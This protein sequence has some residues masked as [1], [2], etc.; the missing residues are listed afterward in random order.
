M[1]AVSDTPADKPQEKKDIVVLGGPTDD[2]KGTRVVRLKE[3]SISVGEVRAL[4]EGKPITGEVVKLTPVQERVCSVETL[5][6][7]PQESRS[8]NKPAQVANNAYRK[9]WDAIFG[10]S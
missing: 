6:A 4:E 9:G 5:Y 7:P 1:F 3:E 2:G 10:A 8:T